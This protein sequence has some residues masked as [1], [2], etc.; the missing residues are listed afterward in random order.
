MSASE[1][2]CDEPEGEL[3]NQQQFMDTHEEVFDGLHIEVQHLSI[4]RPS[5]HTSSP[6]AS[7]SPWK[8][9]AAPV[10][11]PSACCSFSDLL[12][13]RRSATP[14]NVRKDNHRPASAKA[15]EH[16]PKRAKGHGAASSGALAR[17]SLG[18]RS[19][20]HIAASSGSR[21]P[22]PSSAKQQA[23]ARGTTANPGMKGGAREKAVAADLPGFSE[24]RGNY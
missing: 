3:A 5:S 1:R 10:V 14:R 24:S 6:N 22:R 2:S 21:R 16:S 12:A 13:S 11:N 23:N 8:F 19:T 17:A 4:S 18:S 7:S 15:H 20:G 9:G